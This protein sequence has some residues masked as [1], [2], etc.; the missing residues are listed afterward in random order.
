MIILNTS[1]ESKEVAWTS[2]N[3]GHLVVL[4][5]L[6]KPVHKNVPIEGR[7]AYAK[8][9][10]YENSFIALL[11][12]KSD[13]VFGVFLNDNYGFIC[14]NSPS[15]HNYE[16]FKDGHFGGLV[17]GGSQMGIYK[18]GALIRES[19]WGG[20]NLPTFWRLI[21]DGWEEVDAKNL[22]EHDEWI[23]P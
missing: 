15:S 14:A 12:E 23:I 9:E 16:I 17:S 3:G 7:V 6:G 8:K 5:K 13:E 20:L 22:V 19:S 4:N 11:P 2:K 1:L 18:V 10:Y 21:S